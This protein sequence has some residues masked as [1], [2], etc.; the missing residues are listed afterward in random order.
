ME[1]GLDNQ[2]FI[3]IVVGASSLSEENPTGSRCSRNGKTLSD[4]VGSIDIHRE[5]ANLSS[6]IRLFVLNHY[7]ALVL[8]Y[9]ARHR[10]PLLWGIIQNAKYDLDRSVA[11]HS[12]RTLFRAKCK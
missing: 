8:W 11:C 5:H 9:D 3:G 2:A 12:P 1:G 7:Q 6:A 4:L 10:R